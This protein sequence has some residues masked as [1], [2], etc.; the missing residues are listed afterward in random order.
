M[1]RPLI[2]PGFLEN[3]T[4]VVGG[5]AKLVCKV[6]RPDKTKVQWLK[7]D[8]SSSLE[9]NQG[10]QVHLRALTVRTLKMLA[11]FFT[12]CKCS[13]NI[14]LSIQPLQNNGSKVNTL[15]LTNVSL[16]DAGEYICL[17]QSVHSGQTV[18]AM[19]SAWV[20]VLPGNGSFKF[21]YHCIQLKAL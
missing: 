8:V 19:E 6:H 7:T 12:R 18:Q 9:E 11:A 17:A 15:H 5:Q 10:E 21:C 4:A 14:V 16:E 13:H 1:S 2:L 3:S 20:H